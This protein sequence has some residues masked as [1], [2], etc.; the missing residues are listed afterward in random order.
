[1]DK[2]SIVCCWSN[3]AQAYHSYTYKDNS[4]SMSFTDFIL[5]S[6]NCL[7]K[8]R[9]RLRNKPYKIYE[10]KETRHLYAG[11]ETYLPRYRLNLKINISLEETQYAQH[12]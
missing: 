7:F 4:P 12:K 9:N 10:I 5:F 11:V 8:F 1:M 3:Y 2:D 6:T